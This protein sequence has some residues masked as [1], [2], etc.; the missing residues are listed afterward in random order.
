VKGV[1]GA[2]ERGMEGDRGDGWGGGRKMNVCVRAWCVRNGGLLRAYLW[3]EEEG[4][5]GE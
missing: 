2:R 1:D 3:E 4:G 5:R